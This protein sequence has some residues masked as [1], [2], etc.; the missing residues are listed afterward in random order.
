[1]IWAALAVFTFFAILAAIAPF[2]LRRT[3]GGAPVHES[4]V[5]EMAFYKSQLADID[6]DAAQGL[7]GEADADL[8]RA[9]AA[10]RLL[11]AERASRPLAAR[12]TSRAWAA[13]AVALFVPVLALGLY[14]KLGRPD[15]PDMP[16]A[17]RMA[18]SKAETQV[19]NAIVNIEKHLAANPNDGRGWQVLAPVY[20]KLG[21]MDDAV[22]AFR[23]SLRLNGD[24]AVALADYAEALIFA[25]KG[26]VPEEARKALAR[27]VELDPAAGKARYYLGLA[28]E[29]AGEPASAAEIWSKL[30]ADSPPNSPLAQGL[31]ERIA[32]LEGKPTAADV[33]KLAPQERDDAIRQMVEGLAARLA[34][35]GGDAESWMRLV[36]AYS[37]MKELD[38]ARDTLR[39]ARK[40][41][42]AEAGERLN[43]L[44]RELGLEG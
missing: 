20:L 16:R 32:R 34:R 25:G 40:A 9:E 41:L 44:A 37:V 18:E 19:E 29:Q 31:R 15:L 6:R 39:D 28:A 5:D 35:E 3:A 2:L 38:K 33:A 12:A 43:A 30:A 24:S 22:H 8:A 1:M 17:E 7:I 14:M 11:A 10:R 36:R 27:A 13:A 23:E 21:R 42:G 26:N 4:G